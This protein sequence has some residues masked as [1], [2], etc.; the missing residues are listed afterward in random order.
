M[1]IKSKM[2][3]LI[4]RTG[5]FFANCDGNYDERERMFIKN[6]VAE[7]KK[8]ESDVTDDALA[9]VTESLDSVYTLSEIIAETKSY[10]TAFNPNE[11][12]ALL[13]VLSDFISKVINADSVLSDKE[14]ENFAQWKSALYE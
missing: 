7:L 14:T 2:A 13:D 8:S 10:L 1:D 5:V 12:K 9:T 3:I 11:K 6:F 4:A